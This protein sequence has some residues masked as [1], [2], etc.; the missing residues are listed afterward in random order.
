VN[1]YIWGCRETVTGSDVSNMQ[2]PA[3]GEERGTGMR[4]AKQVHKI[5]YVQSAY[6]RETGDYKNHSYV[7]RV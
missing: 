1:Q 7:G 6:H 2:V 4:T 5:V 3:D